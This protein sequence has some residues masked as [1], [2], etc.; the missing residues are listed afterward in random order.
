MPT[1]QHAAPQYAA[2]IPEIRRISVQ[3]L[4]WALAEGW[5]DFLATRGDLIVIGLLYPIIC[6]VAV[7]MTF[8]DPL[9][10]LLFPLVAGLSI[11][12]PAAA[13]G[14]YELA[15]RREE[16]RDTSWWHFLDPLNGRSRLPLAVLTGGLGVLM[17]AWLLGA[18]AIYAATF[19][20]D[21]PM[22]V[23]DLFGRLFTT[24]AG[25]TLIVLG[26]LAG[27]AFAVASLVF[28]VV[29]FP[30]V[31]DKSVD[32]G[33]AVRTSLAAVRKNPYEVFGWGLR[34]AALLLIGLLPAAIG[35][36]VVLPWLG[37]ST[38]HLYTRLVVR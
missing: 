4:N 14:F 22:R 26:N 24:R 23:G 30:M 15:R 7:F 20:A 5:K 28:A 36:A 37:Y 2:Q 33:L 12:G 6:L 9:L 21:T 19:G 1:L 32:P 16:K 17:I 11:V 34:V 3:D 27:F 18:Y 35:L 13:S 8:N 29:S 31:V 25:W 10:P 38:W